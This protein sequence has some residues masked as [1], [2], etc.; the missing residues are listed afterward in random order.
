MLLKDYDLHTV[1]NAFQGSV[2]TIAYTCVHVHAVMKW[3]QH[4]PTYASVAAFLLLDSIFGTLFGPN[5]IDRSY[6]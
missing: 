4:M 2:H 6:Q 3:Y 5:L 1:V